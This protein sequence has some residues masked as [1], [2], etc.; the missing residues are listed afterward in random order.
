MKKIYGALL[1]IA[2]ILFGITIGMNNAFSA[3]LGGIGLLTVLIFFSWG[4]K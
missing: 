4:D 3:L 2:V 1:G